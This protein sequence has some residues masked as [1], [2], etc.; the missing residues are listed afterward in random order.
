MHCIR[1]HGYSIPYSYLFF[2]AGPFV[3]THW[4]T[5]QNLRT[6]T[7]ALIGSNTEVLIIISLASTLSNYT[8][9]GLHLDDRHDMTKT[10][11]TICVP[12]VLIFLFLHVASPMI[13]L[14]KYPKW[15]KLWIVSIFHI[16]LFRVWEELLPPAAG[17]VRSWMQSG[18]SQSTSIH[19]S[20]PRFLCR[21]RIC[22]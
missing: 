18:G 21:E 16:L 2:L 17:G 1:W 20:L 13:L 15:C 5:I 9:D 12:R 8:L 22:A 11:R 4:W 19:Y 3:Q 10:I 14:Q 7:A 6:V